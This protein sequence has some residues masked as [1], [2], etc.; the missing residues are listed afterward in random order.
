MTTLEPTAHRAD[1]P[2]DPWSQLL[3]K[4][5]KHQDR[6]A[7]QSLFQHFGPQIKHYAIANGLP[8]Q[9]EELVQE[10]FISIW[11][12]SCLY[13][14]RKAAASTWIFTIARNQRV[15]LLRKLRRTNKEITVET[16]DLWQVPGE[17][18]DEPV[19][20]LHRLMSERRIRESLVHL[21]E[22]QI[23]VIAKVYMEQ[24][25]HQTVAEELDIPLGTVKSRVR[26]ALKKLK[27]LLQ[28]Q[29]S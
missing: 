28:D 26:L 29:K 24:K 5:G 23:T 27:V 16:E 19:T 12:R 3:E 13:D 1:S 15:D 8:H 10:V 17:Q 22:E 9:A 21:P 14:W 25:S 6:E 11:R 18:E 2:R 7:F 20:S 4:V